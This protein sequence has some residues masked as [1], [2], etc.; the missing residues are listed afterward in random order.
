MSIPGASP[1]TRAGRLLRSAALQSFTVSAPSARELDETR[2]RILGVKVSSWA[3][4]QSNSGTALAVT[5]CAPE[6]RDGA[7]LMSVTPRTQRR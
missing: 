7:S 1:H 6:D 3:D 4:E 5:V 2:L